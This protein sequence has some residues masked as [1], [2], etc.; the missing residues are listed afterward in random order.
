[1]KTIKM[2][3]MGVLSGLIVGLW[4]G[5]NIGKGNPIFS[6]PFV[7]ENLQNKIKVRVGESIEQFGEDI[8]GKINK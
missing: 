4:L 7:K 1:M 3:F 8:K 5:V 2:L 6:N